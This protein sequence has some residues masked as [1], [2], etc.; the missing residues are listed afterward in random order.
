MK[1]K[2][3]IVLDLETSGLNPRK[4]EIIKC[5]AFCSTWDKPKV[6]STREEI[7][8][9]CSSH[10]PKVFHNAIFDLRY[11]KAHNYE[12]V[13]PFH[14]TMLMA[15]LVDPDTYKLTLKD[16][17]GLSTV[18]LKHISRKL[19][20]NDSLKYYQEM[21]DWLAYHKLDSA[22]ITKAPNDL[23]EKYAAEDAANT[24]KV[25][26]HFRD[27]LIKIAQWQEGQK[28]PTI[29]DYYQNEIMP[30]IPVIVNMENTGIKIDVQRL[31]DAQGRLEKEQADYLNKLNKETYP[32]IKQAEDILYHQ[33]IEKKCSKNKTGKL[34][35]DPPKIVFNWNSS[36]H[37]KLLFFKLLNEQPLTKT[38]KGNYSMDS[39]TLEGLQAKYP[40]VTYLLEYKILRKLSSTYLS[41][42]LT[43][44]EAGR[45]HASFNLCGT[46][47]GRFSSSNPNIQNLPKHG[48]IK[49]LFVP[50]DNNVFIYADYS[51]LELRLAA[52]LSQDKLLLKAY[53][54]NLDLHQMTADFIKVD[55]SLG[56][57]INFAIIYNASGWRI[58]EILGYMQGI[59]FD[60]MEAKRKAA[61]QGDVIIQE[62][63]GKYSGLKKYLEEQKNYMLKYKI[64]QSPYGKI[65][66]LA[67]LAS[68]ERS[69][70]N[71]AIKQGFN[72]PIQSMGA[73]I[74]KRA[75]IKLTEDKYQIVNQVHDSIFIEHPQEQ[76]M[77]FY[78]KDVKKC[79][80]SVIK[81]SVPLV[82]EPKLLT[83]FEDK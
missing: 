78:I 83:S 50:N 39:H 29:I 32:Y 55:R 31:V 25:F 30:L 27:L 61:K 64:T 81:L 53:K 80:E 5:A 70:F 67:G 26:E 42:L 12:V 41:S 3:F 1:N 59:H 75:M 6:L 63:F 13:G 43:L 68:T 38:R 56:K 66:R 54:D 51:Q 33:S 21:Q 37:L 73:S 36:E 19:L 16:D 28:L 58:A 47:T 24:A 44:Q 8:E 40:W 77:S 7:Q 62:L 82:A 79:M 46:A 18:S 14:D 34:K 71:H 60:D 35:K 65:R 57:T 11:L 49:S 15:N 20:G 48:A 45:I 2:D 10:L 69:V 74:C 23:L 9:V 22:S 72:F 4:G 52:H 76:D 17:A